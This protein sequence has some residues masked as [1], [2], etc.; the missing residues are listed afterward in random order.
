MI[1]K[2]ISLICAGLFFFS[3]GIFEV[4]V[5]FKLK[6][7][8]SQIDK[9]TKSKPYWAMGVYMDNIPQTEQNILGLKSVPLKL[10]TKNEYTHLPIPRKG[11]EIRGIYCNG[12]NQ[13]EMIGI[14]DSITYA[15]DKDCIL[16]E[17]KCTD[18]Q[19]LK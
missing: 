6:K 15:L 17:C 12:E 9:L 16:V 7:L 19:R 8:D 18:I 11:E 13:F 14:V 1:L 3:L 5:I 2:I 10:Y 4:F